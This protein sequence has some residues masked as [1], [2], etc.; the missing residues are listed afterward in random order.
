[1][2]FES[3]GVASF[4]VQIWADRMFLEPTGLLYLLYAGADLIVFEPFGIVGANILNSFH[5]FPICNE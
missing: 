1:M 2:A 4:L 3:L 5:G